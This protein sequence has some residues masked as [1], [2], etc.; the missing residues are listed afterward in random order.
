VVATDPDG[1]HEVFFYH[2]L[3]GSNKLIDRDYD[4]NDKFNEDKGKESNRWPEE[5]WLDPFEY[6]T[7]LLSPPN[8]TIKRSVVMRLRMFSRPNKNVSYANGWMLGNYSLWDMLR[9]FFE[10]CTFRFDYFSRMFGIHKVP[11]PAELKKDYF[12]ASVISTKKRISSSQSDSTS[13]EDESDDDIEEY[14]RNEPIG[15][16]RTFRHLQCR[17][18]ICI[19]DPFETNRTIGPTAEGQNQISLEFLRAIGLMS[20]IELC[21]DSSVA[22]KHIDKLFEPYKVIIKKRRGYQSCTEYYRHP[23]MQSLMNNQNRIMRSD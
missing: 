16:G 9:D 23:S 10:Y 13:F 1:D 8:A 18:Y 4:Y 21:H 7:S 6:A 14:Q 17:R 3:C 5:N 15:L 12:H 2:P 11:Y 20:A 22:K 19:S